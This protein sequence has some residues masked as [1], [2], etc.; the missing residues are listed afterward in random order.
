MYI[1]SI[2][3]LDIDECNNHVSG[4]S[5]SCINTPGSYVCDCNPGYKKENDGAT[6]RGKVFLLRKLGCVLLGWSKI[7][8]I[9]VNQRNL[10]I[11][12]HWFWSRSPQ[13]N[14][15]S[16]V[17]LVRSFWWWRSLEGRPWLSRI[18]ICTH[19]IKGI[20][21]KLSWKARKNYILPVYNV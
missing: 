20:R 12:D 18:G 11:L 2:C 13:T 16:L 5:Q 3:S 8:R 4:C 19:Q 10:V 21:R 6:C 15:A 9:C 17:R 1:F 7:T 14:A